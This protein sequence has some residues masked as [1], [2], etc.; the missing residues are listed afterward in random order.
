MV[1]LSSEERSE[2]ELFI[3]RERERPSEEALLGAVGRRR[4]RRDEQIAQKVGVQRTTLE[5]IRKRYVEEVAGGGTVGT[6]RPGKT[7]LLD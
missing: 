4:R 6:T 2:L 3:G 5:E 7:P 1:E